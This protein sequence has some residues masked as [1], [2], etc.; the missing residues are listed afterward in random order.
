[1][2]T[3]VI[4]NPRA[5]KMKSKTALFDIAEVLCGAG[6]DLTVKIT[7]GSGDATRFAKQAAA[8]EYDLVV[9]SGGDGTFNETVTGIITS[10]KKIPIGYIPAGSTNDFA[11]TL[12]ISTVP[13]KAASA[14]V[15]GTPLVIDA[16]KFGDDRF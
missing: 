7:A 3:M 14:I 16:G 1:M 6:H 13:K 10:G 9:C 8:Q 11:R 12:G 4:I 2:K 15:G 5:G